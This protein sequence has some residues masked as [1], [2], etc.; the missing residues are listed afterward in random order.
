[1]D[2][3]YIVFKREDFE[4]TSEVLLAEIEDAVV[5]R[6]QDIFAAPALYTYY[7]SIQVAMTLLPPN[8]RAALLPIADYFHE[9][10]TMADKTD[11]RKIPDL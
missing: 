7:N 8:E 11:H 10:A 2:Q 1:M 5:I 4:N 9:M 6:L 3:K